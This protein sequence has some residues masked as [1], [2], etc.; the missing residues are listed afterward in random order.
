VRSRASLYQAIDRLLRLELIEIT[1]TVRGRRHPDR[2][3]YALT[4]AGRNTARRWLAEMLADVSG[5]FPDFPAAVSVLTMLAPGEAAD[6]LAQRADAVAAELADI[7]TQLKAVGDLPEVFV[8]EE[9]HRRAL[10]RAELTW[11]RGTTTGLRD[12]KLAWTGWSQDA[13]D[14]RPAPP[15]AT[16]T[17]KTTSR[18]RSS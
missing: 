17:P 18:K 7:A 10:L 12:G 16:T 5:D 6:L 8:L 15:T 11:L 1:E 13:A 3:V 9:T 14:R 2:T 4:T